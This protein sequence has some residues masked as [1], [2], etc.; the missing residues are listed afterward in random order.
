MEGYN[1]GFRQSPLEALG[2][3]WDEI[4]ASKQLS[5]RV[6]ISP[7]PLTSCIAALRAEKKHQVSAR[8]HRF[9]KKRSPWRSSLRA[10]NRPALVLAH[11]KNVGRA[12]LS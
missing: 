11:N 5:N 2:E 3:H 12:A 1:G 4:Q 8:R 7:L 10:S 6:V 9:R